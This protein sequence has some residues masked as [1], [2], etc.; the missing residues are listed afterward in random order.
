M[1]AWIRIPLKLVLLGLVG[2]VVL[3]AVIT[4]A[5][6][7][8]EPSL[9]EADELRN[10]RFRTPLTVYSRDGLLISQYGDEKRIPAEFD[11]IPQVL[12][13]AIIAAEDDQFYQHSGI[14]LYSTLRAVFNYGVQ[15]ITGSDDTPPGGS[16]ITQQVTRTTDL[17][18]REVSIGRKV[19]EIF[20]AF[21]IE[22]E[23]TKDEILKLY[24]NTYFFGQRSYGVVQAARTYFNKDLK[25]LS[26]SEAA[27]IAGIPTAPSVNNPYN[28]PE[29]ART[30]RS[31]VLRR[32]QELGYIAASE[33]QAA[34]SEPIISQKFDV[35]LEVEAGYIAS[36]VI[37]WC[38]SKFGDKACREDGL[39]IYTTI[40]A[41]AQRAANMSLR[42]TLEAYDRKHGW[43]GPIGYFDLASIGL[44]VADGATADASPAELAVETQ[45]EGIEF[46]AEPTEVLRT[47]LGD[48]PDRFGAEAAV[49]LSVDEESDLA[50][51]YLRSTGVVSVGVDAVSWARRYRDKD[52]TGNTPQSV[53]D[54][55][56]PGDIVRFRRGADGVYELAQVP[57]V[58]DLNGSIDTYAEGALVSVDP[59]DGA[60]V[61]L[62]GGYAHEHSPFNRAAT[63]KRQPGSSFKP[64]FYSAAL[65][66]RYT[67]STFV[68][69]VYD[70]YFDP[71]RE[72]R[73]CVENY[74]GDY[75]GLIPL[76][77]VFFRSKNASADRVIRDVGASYVADYV[78]RFGFDPIQDE[79][80]ASLALG[81]LVVTPLELANGYAILANGGFAVGIAD[82]N[83]GGEVKPYFVQRADN[84]DG[85]VLYDSSLSVRML[86]PEGEEETEYADERLIEW[87]AEL[88]GRLRCAEQVAS[89][90]ITFLITDVLK[91]V[92]RNGSGAAAYRELQRGD[93]AG[94]TGTTNGPTDVWFAGF[95]PDLVA[96]A[97]VG[98]DDATR[99]LGR[100]EQGGVTAIPAWIDY[101]AVM[102]EG[103]PE[104]SLPQPTGIVRRL[105]NPETGLIAA[106][107]NTGRKE[108]EY[109]L[110]ENQPDQESNVACVARGFS[111]GNGGGDG[112]NEGTNSVSGSLFE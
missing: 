14:D 91:K 107:C 82:E 30:R 1:N 42:A 69:D 31:Y 8:V 88:F 44:A 100:T 70:C 41:R 104:R 75:A 51:V 78:Q 64:F 81:S 32:M 38:Q 60:V 19:A 77:E 43:R 35:E 111:R 50:E 37:D 85:E 98:F 61:A 25:D 24:L 99:E 96:V 2:S 67:L 17:L 79:T 45:L 66:D 39:V 54:A 103:Q 97:R 76:R 22:R 105:I 73:H 55:L 20:L 12:K 27:I 21:R 15:R 112:D 6:Y 94:K 48:Y 83:D 3:A 57:E 106:D 87:R 9:P 72:A 56:T 68:N 28:G 80:N 86:C 34:L 102:L 18:S 11:E 84:A 101:M 62:V 46:D 63:A 53:G 10:V 13:D 40:D 7:Y 110:F 23:F 89:P 4:G 49:V 52:R 71:V 109:F 90:Q 26:L 74:S 29:N 47:L 33:R 58:G 5:Y 59:M 92:A 16:T 36:M 93:I 95:T 108:W 65:A